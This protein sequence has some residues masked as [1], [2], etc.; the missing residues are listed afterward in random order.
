MYVAVSYIG[1]SIIHGEIIP[2]CAFFKIKKSGSES[3]T[4]SPSPW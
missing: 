4:P 2:T 1:S 3:F